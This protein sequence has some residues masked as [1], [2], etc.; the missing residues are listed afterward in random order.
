MY[1]PSVLHMLSASIHLTV[2]NSFENITNLK[3]LSPGHSKF[4]SQRQWRVKH[5]DN[6]LMVSEDSSYCH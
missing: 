4:K 2:A 1:G 5:L 3:A 6:R